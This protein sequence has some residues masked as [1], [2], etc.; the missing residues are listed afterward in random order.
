[1]RQSDLFAKYL[2]FGLSFGLIIQAL[3][4][5]MVVVGHGH[6]LTIET[7]CV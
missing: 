4:N 5:L 7:V 3:L 1:M 2:S 6:V